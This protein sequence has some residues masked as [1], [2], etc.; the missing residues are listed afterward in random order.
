MRRPET[1]ACLVLL[2]LLQCCCCATPWGDTG[3]DEAGDRSTPGPNR[4]SLGLHAKTRFCCYCCCGR[5][6]KEVSF[7]QAITRGK[8]AQ[9][10]LQQLIT[11]YCVGLCRNLTRDQPLCRQAVARYLPFQYLQSPGWYCYPADVVVK[12]PAFHCVNDCGES[13]ICGDGPGVYS[14]TT[15]GE[16]GEMERLIR[17]NRYRWCTESPCQRQTQPLLDAYCREALRFACDP[18]SPSC[19]GGA[20]ARKEVG[21]DASAG[22]AWRCYSPSDLTRD[23]QTAQCVRGCDP[24]PVSCGDGVKGGASSRHWDLGGALEKIIAKAAGSYAPYGSDS[25]LQ[26]MLDDDCRSAMKATCP[27]SSST[28]P[29]GAIARKDV[30][31]RNDKEPQWRCYNPLALRKDIYSSLCVTDCGDEVPCMDGIAL[32]GNNVY[33]DQ[34]NVGKKIQEFKKITCPTAQADHTAVPISNLQRRLDE[35]C[36][37]LLKDVCQGDLCPSGAVARKDVGDKRQKE[38]QWRCYNPTQL[39]IMVKTAIC[40]TDCGAEAACG[41]GVIAGGSYSHWTRSK[42]IE[43]LIEKYKSTGCK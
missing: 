36:R 10:K 35:Y 9:G 42:E 11:D 20:V 39:T 6:G 1:A 19:S 18:S 7:V 29:G 40:V 38:R 3:V 21:D 24:D 33:Y 15:W 8:D 41:D 37:D 28:C 13:I 25:K 27:P 31:T 17:D 26:K 4:E 23:V 22:K 34:Y 32:S 14:R 2:L 16:G 30:K 43:G 5:A 12:T